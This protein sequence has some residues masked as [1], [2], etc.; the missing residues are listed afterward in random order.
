[1]SGFRGFTAVF[2]GAALAL[3]LDGAARAEGGPEESAE[4]LYFKALQLEQELGPKA[5]EAACEIYGVIAKRHLEEPI[6]AVALLRLGICKRKLGRIEEARE[7]LIRAVERAGDRQD[8][9]RRAEIELRMLEAPGRGHPP[10]PGHE[11]TDWLEAMRQAWVAM[12]LEPHEIERRLKIET[13][14]ALREHQRRERL[15][16][17]A[18][19]L[20][21]KNVPKEEAEKVLAEYDRAIRTVNARLREQDERLAQRP[22]G[23]R[24]RPPEGERPLGVREFPW[25]RE[26]GPRPGPDQAER[27]FREVLLRELRVLREEV[28]ELR[29]EVCRLRDATLRRPAPPAPESGPR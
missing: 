25:G 18:R 22:E 23:E 28:R 24:P 5:V 19:E 26:A 10:E 12:G 2:L 17:L 27:E 15:A 8:L 14:A 16:E 4:A 21:E 11:G 1:M 29:E 20:R 13:Q 3:A 9:R 6:A 7:A